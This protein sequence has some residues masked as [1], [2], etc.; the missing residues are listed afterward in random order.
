MKVVIIRM[1][2]H[3]ALVDPP[4]H[5]LT[6]GRGPTLLFLHGFNGGAGL[7][8]PNIAD[9]APAGF[10][11]LA[12]DLPGWGDSPPPPGFTYRMPELVAMLVRFLDQLA[13]GPVTVVGHSFG[14]AAALHL[15]LTHPERVSRLVL[16]NSAALTED[17][18]LHYRLLGIP[19]LGEWLL[20]PSPEAARRQLPSFAVGDLS[21]IPEDVLAYVERVIMHPWFVKTSLRWVRHN[22]VLWYGARAIAVNHRLWEIAQP[23]LVLTGDQDPIA[24]AQYSREA[25]GLLPRGKLIEFPGAMHLLPLDRRAEFARAVIEFALEETRDQAAQAQQAGEG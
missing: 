24:P 1:L 7:W 16:A 11:C 21:R 17:A 13:P 14:G 2:E 18:I 9:I 15:A 4:V 25:A 8:A 6:A 5:Y 19:G 10:R 23:T 3:G 20:R 22:K 12:P